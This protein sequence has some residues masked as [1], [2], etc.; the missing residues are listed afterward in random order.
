VQG[1]G[2]TDAEYRCFLTGPGPIKAI[3]DDRLPVSIPNSEVEATKL[4]LDADGWLHKLTTILSLRK[5]C[6]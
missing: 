3:D 6:R 5:E 1:G 2:G 4:K